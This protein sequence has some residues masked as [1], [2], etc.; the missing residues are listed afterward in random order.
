MSW[1]KTLR[2]FDATALRRAYDILCEE[3]AAAF[4]I[5]PGDAAKDIDLIL[6]E[7]RLQYKDLLES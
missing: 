2:D 4:H 7:S 1:S 5:E 3:W 6:H